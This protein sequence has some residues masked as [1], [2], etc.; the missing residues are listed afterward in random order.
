MTDIRG[1]SGN[2]KACNVSACARELS[3]LDATQNSGKRIRVE[4]GR[5][6]SVS[7]KFRVSLACKG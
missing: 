5:K 1:E 7:T 2:Y 6:A 3:L 4:F